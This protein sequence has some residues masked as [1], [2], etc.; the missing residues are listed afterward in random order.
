MHLVLGFGDTGASFLRYLKTKNLPF[1]IMDSRTNPPGL[2]QFKSL[3]KKH[4]SLGSFDE[5][6]LDK[7]KS[8]LVSPGIS[9]NNKVLTR[10]RKL[11]I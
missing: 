6:I 1:L 3:N 4:L 9:F 11:G 2:S 5:A 8:V 7:V 10:A